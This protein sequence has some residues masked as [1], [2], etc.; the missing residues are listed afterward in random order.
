MDFMWI[1][2]AVAVFIK[3]LKHG[4][5]VGDFLLGQAVITVLVESLKDGVRWWAVVFIQF[6]ASFAGGG[7]QADRQNGKRDKEGVHGNLG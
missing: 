4:G 7:R 6:R 2:L 3:L 5:G 1:E